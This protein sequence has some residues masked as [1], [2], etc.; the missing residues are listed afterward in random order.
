MIGNSTGD[1]GGGL[2]FDEIGSDGDEATAYIA[3]TTI[4]GNTA[5]R[6]GGIGVLDFFGNDPALVIDSSTISGNTVTG[7]GGGLWFQHATDEE[8]DTF[9]VV[10]IIDSTVS[11]TR[12]GDDGGAMSFEGDGADET[13]LELLHSTFSG[14]TAANSADGVLLTDAADL[15][16]SHTILADADISLWISDPLLTEIEAE[17]SIV[18]DSFAGDDVLLAGPGM[19]FGVDP[20]LGPLAPNGGPTD[21][22]LLLSGSPAIDTGDPAFVPPPA[23]DQRGDPRVIQRI[24]IGAVEVPAVLPA[25]GG[26]MGLGWPLLAV[27]LLAVGAGAVVVRRYLLH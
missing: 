21:T 12:A 18:V 4:S 15:V 3:R 1:E 11:G 27:L 23:L 20:R 2:L 17:Y 16:L 25:T 7:S 9:G 8:Y 19:Q 6:G 26:S 5:P 10:R 24:D 14:N 13:R 22:H